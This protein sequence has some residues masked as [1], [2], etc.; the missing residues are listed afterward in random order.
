VTADP[1]PVFYGELYLRSTRP[2]LAEAVT[3]AEVTY[4]DAHLKL[5]QHP[6]VTL[7]LGCGHGRH[8]GP[9]RALGHQVVGIDFDPLSLAEAHPKAPV[10]R[11]DFFRLPFRDASLAAAYAMYNTVFSIEDHRQLPL[12]REVARCLKP[13]GLLIL[14]GT[15]RA[16]A[17]R[18]PTASFDGQLPDGSHLVERCAFDARTGHDHVTRE[19]T[20]PDGRLMAASFFIRYYRLDELRVLLEQAGFEVLWVHGALDGSAPS[21]DSSDQLVG[22]EKRE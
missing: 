19:L 10:L 6:G 12:F 21:P 16:Q 15:A 18:E 17:E 1:A 4:L 11:G 22:V 14:Q 20:L 13:G 9:L 2:F 7:D 8:L 3:A 5:A